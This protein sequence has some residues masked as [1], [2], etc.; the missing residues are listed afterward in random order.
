V[1]LLWI[2]SWILAPVDGMARAVWIGR[3]V[4]FTHAGNQIAGTAAVGMWPASGNTQ[5]KETVTQHCKRGRAKEW[6]TKRRFEKTHTRA[7]KVKEH[8]HIISSSSS[9][10]SRLVALQSQFLLS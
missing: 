1:A 8:N 10:L 9:S 4:V 2:S 3:W 7:Q 5:R 6:S